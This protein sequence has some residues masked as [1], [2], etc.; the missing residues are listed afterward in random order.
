[1]NV[2]EVRQRAADVRSKLDS[3]AEER[4][5]KA[6]QLNEEA[7]A[8][9]KE[10]NR[11]FLKAQVEDKINEASAHGHMDTSITQS[12]KDN[13]KTWNHYVRLMNELADEL[14]KAGFTVKTNES[15]EWS[16]GLAMLIS[17]AEDAPA[18]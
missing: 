18:E 2:T 6:H 17:W 8:T 5:T 13:L 1:M 7:Y 15:K 11:P 16:R 3:E 4:R 14:R 10:A 12:Q 9:Y